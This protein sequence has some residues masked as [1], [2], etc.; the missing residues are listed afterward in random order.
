MELTSPAQFLLL[1]SYLFKVGSQDLNKSFGS[2][3]MQVLINC[4]DRC[5][6]FVLQFAEPSY[7]IEM[8]FQ[9]Q[10]VPQFVSLDFV[11]HDLVPVLFVSLQR[12][13]NLAFDKT[14]M[15]RCSQ[16]AFFV[17]YQDSPGLVF[18]VIE[19]FLHTDQISPI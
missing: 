2:F 17:K 11:L 8:N 1:S 16:I 10:I 13:E 19:N 15:F 12:L 4:S 5:Q 6:F 9:E 14:Q 18:K 3:L 7:G